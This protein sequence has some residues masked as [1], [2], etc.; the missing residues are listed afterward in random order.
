MV[1]G[2]MR[3]EKVAESREQSGKHK[4]DYNAISR[5]SIDRPDSLDAEKITGQ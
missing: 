2:V 3:N 5:L 4:N 1:I